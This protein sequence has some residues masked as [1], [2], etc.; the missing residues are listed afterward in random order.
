MPEIV[1]APEKH[2][3]LDQGIEKGVAGKLGGV[4]DPIPP[5]AAG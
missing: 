1:G 3:A 2:Y 5:L 4:M